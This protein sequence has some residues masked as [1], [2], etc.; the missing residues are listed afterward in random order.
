MAVSG[1]GKQLHQQ[2]FSV[3]FTRSEKTVSGASGTW[4]VSAQRSGN[5]V[6]GDAF[7]GKHSFYV[8]C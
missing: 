7:V 4:T 3:D 2:S 1:A 6:A 8:Q 5:D